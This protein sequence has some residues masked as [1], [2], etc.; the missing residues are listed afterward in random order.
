MGPKIDLAHYD[1]NGNLKTP[2]L[3]LLSIAYLCRYLLI[4]LVSGLSTFVAVRRGIG[5]DLPELPPVEGLFSSIP[6]AL[7]FAL[8]LTR[9]RL[10][11][12]ALAKYVSR[13]GRSVLLLTAVV[14]AVLLFYSL[15]GEGY[16]DGLFEVI[17]LVLLGYATV[18][19][20]KSRSAQAYFRGYCTHA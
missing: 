19:I 12:G 3:L 18:Y 20:W 16:R 1:H 7:I 13:H 11:G 2:P 5:V 6:A 17:D 15:I 14:Q 4:F 9:E 8:V 10:L